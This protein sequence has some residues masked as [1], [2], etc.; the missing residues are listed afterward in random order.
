MKSFPVL[1]AHFT[2]S[3]VL[4]K[5]IKMFVKA[6][7]FHDKVICMRLGDPATLEGLLVK[8]PPFLKDFWGISRTVPFLYLLSLSLFNISRNN[9]RRR[10]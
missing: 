8:S 3:K 2:D 4:Q 6:L 7:F 5:D 10:H 1:T 9:L